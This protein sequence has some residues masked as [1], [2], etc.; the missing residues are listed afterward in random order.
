MSA[1]QPVDPRTVVRECIVPFHQAMMGTHAT[2]ADDEVV[3]GVRA[4]AARLPAPEVVRLLFAPWQA[5][6]MA[7]WYAAAAPRP[8]LGQALLHA[9]EATT[10][11]GDAPPVLVAILDHVDMDAVSVEETAVAL[12]D[13]HRRDLGGGWGS[14]GLAC[15]AAEAFVRRT[16][17]PTH[18]PPPGEADLEMLAA[19]RA[20]SRR[21][22]L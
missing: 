17:T 14:A 3:A 6:V 2:T 18:L 19:L 5:R 20:V 22:R 9:L 16:R 4:C 7:A 1:P 13:Y 8:D 12:E 21:L 15:A 11:D 10:G